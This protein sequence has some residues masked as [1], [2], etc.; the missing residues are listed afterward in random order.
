MSGDFS[1]ELW[2]YLSAAEISLA[3]SCSAKEGGP[4]AV[5]YGKQQIADDSKYCMI[6]NSDGYI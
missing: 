4:A 5:T 6:E 2:P 1:P 3:A